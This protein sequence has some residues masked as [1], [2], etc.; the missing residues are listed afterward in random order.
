MTPYKA[1][2]LCEVIC[3]NNILHHM[4]VL[5]LTEKS[6]FQGAVQ[7]NPV[8]SLGMKPVFSVL[9]KIIAELIVK[10]SNLLYCTFLCSLSHLAHKVIKLC[11]LARSGL[12][13]G[14]LIRLLAFNKETHSSSLCLAKSARPSSQD[15]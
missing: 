1:A 6:H 5:L 3:R 9:G 2:A 13:S 12:S 11:F 7:K 15:M 4:L 8:L 14:L 10:S